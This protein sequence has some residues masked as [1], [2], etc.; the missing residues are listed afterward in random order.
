MRCR[1]RQPVRPCKPEVAPRIL[2]HW[3]EFKVLLSFLRPPLLTACQPPNQY[4]EQ[5]ELE[6]FDGVSTG[7]YTIGLGQTKMSF[8]DDREGE[9]ILTL[10][11]FRF[12]FPSLEG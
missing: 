1:N 10:P 12:F 8:C 11:P 7:K 9:P 4:V 3:S 5:T 6:K 2:A